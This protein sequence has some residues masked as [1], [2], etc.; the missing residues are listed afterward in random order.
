MMKFLQNYT[1]GALLLGALSLPAHAETPSFSCK[2]DL[3]TLDFTPV[4]TD[5]WKLNQFK[6]ANGLAYQRIHQTVT[7]KNQLEMLQNIHVFYSEDDKE[8]LYLKAEV[9]FQ[10]INMAQKRSKP[11]VK[12]YT[13]KD[14]IKIGKRKNYSN[15]ATVLSLFC[16]K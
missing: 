7:N 9:R 2:V 11:T 13:F 6:E 15:G 12:M 4:F 14:K 1:I 16:F 10:V 5:H 8:H 3:M